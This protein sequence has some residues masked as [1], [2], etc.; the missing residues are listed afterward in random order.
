MIIN[1]RAID[2]RA[3]EEI[4]RDMQESMYQFKTVILGKGKYRTIEFHET[5]NGIKIVTPDLI[6]KIIN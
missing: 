2:P 4:R 3:I 5:K 6:N 1:P